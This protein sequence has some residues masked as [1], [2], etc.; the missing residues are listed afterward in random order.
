MTES[1]HLHGLSKNAE[2]HVLPVQL[3]PP[4]KQRLVPQ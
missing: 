1:S 2:A 3:P 4:R